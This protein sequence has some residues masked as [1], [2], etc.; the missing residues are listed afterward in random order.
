[1]SRIVRRQTPHSTSGNDL[2]YAKRFLT[3]DITNP[4][5]GETHSLGLY[6]MAHPASSHGTRVYGATIVDENSIAWSARLITDGRGCLVVFV[7][8]TSGSNIQ[9]DVKP[10]S[11]RIAI[12]GS[13]PEAIAFS[14]D[15]G[16]TA[17]CVRQ[18]CDA[19][20]LIIDA[21]KPATRSDINR[22]RRRVAKLLHP[23]LG[24]AIEVACRAR[25]MALMN[26]ELDE[27]SSRV[28]A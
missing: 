7:G 2:P 13:L 28:A 18:Y 10:W 26:A 25:A 22:V 11:R 21:E 8:D 27:L 4:N 12:I 20:R 16:T 14:S 3:L 6:L 5:S 1:M 15:N 9:F 19:A 17:I 24:S 23:D